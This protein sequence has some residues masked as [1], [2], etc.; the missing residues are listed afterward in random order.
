[1]TFF[2]CHRST[3]I[4]Y[5]C[6]LRC[7]SWSVILRGRHNRCI[8][9]HRL[10]RA[11]DWISCVVTTKPEFRSFLFFASQ[12]FTMHWNGPL[13]SSPNSPHHTTTSHHITRPRNHVT[14]ESHN[15]PIP[16]SHPS[17]SLHFKSDRIT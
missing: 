3:G 14:S 5:K 9:S 6:V 7:A 13:T 15:I 12:G 10:L 16:S 4:D 11:M 2:R 1:M 17:A 8:A